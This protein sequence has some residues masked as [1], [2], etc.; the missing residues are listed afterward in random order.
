M[1]NN[2]AVASLLFVD[3]T[4]F[5]VFS[6]LL[7]LLIQSAT[8]WLELVLYVLFLQSLPNS[9]IYKGLANWLIKSLIWIL[10]YSML[11]AAWSW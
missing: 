5:K 2:I 1:K 8:L 11:N 9:L 3:V 4:E 6:F 10:A 7:I